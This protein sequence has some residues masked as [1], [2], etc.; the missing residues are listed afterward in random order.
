MDDRQ[1]NK[2]R[3]FN[4]TLTVCNDHK[5][6]WDSVLA[7]D[8]NVTN[9]KDAIDAIG[10]TRAIQETD[11][12]GLVEDRNRIK[13]QQANIALQVLGAIDVFADENDD[14]TLFKK[15]D[16]SFSELVFVRDS[17]AKSRAQLVHDT[18]QPIIAQLADFGIDAAKL[19][20]LTNKMVEFDQIIAKLAHV[21]ED[22][23]AA[24]SLL[25]EHFDDGDTALDRLDKLMPLFKGTH[26]HRA[27]FNAREIID[28]RGRNVISEPGNELPPE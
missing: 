6:E 20:E 7:F 18:A 26:F 8:R 11:K 1:E 9:L 25:P 15:V 12:T 16:F 23:Q 27:Y 4:G 2:L 10:V 19:T 13:E 21:P 14:I 22:Q 17:V 3:M 24:T 5:N 28:R